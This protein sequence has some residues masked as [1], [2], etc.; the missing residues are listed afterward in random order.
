[1]TV[2]QK[3]LFELSLELATKEIAVL[4]QSD[5]ED[6]VNNL[7]DD[8]KK[9]IG[10]SNLYF[11]CKK[12]RLNFV[13]GTLFFD[14]NTLH[15]EFELF[16]KNKTVKKERVVLNYAES[17]NNPIGFELHKTSKSKIII[18]YPNNSSR[19]VPI[20]YIFYMF[21]NMPYRDFS[22]FA[23]HDITNY[24]ILYIGQSVGNKEKSNSFIRTNRGH[25]KLQK[26]LSYTLEHEP[27]YEIFLV[28]ATIQPPFSIASSLCEFY[29]PKYTKD[30]SLQDLKA[31][32]KSHEVK[33]VVNL[34]E[35]CLIKYFQPKYND[36]LKSDKILGTE[37]FIK[38]Y[39]KDHDINSI[40]TVIDTTNLSIEL[41][42]TT[43][44]ATSIHKIYNP[45]HKETG[46]VT[47]ND[48]LRRSEVIDKNQ[49]L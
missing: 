26:I 4:R 46:R 42:S 48:I 12:P 34:M 30:N 24:E 41:F 29:D 21:R 9:M 37:S 47:I 19:T 1:M 45:I 23:N 15:F 40:L 43:R 16:S 39:T 11:I 5:S 18:Y 10:N 13:P 36:R 38:E 27:H 35:A 44:K 7:E 2:K 14:K 22:Q 32:A 31:L 6:G 8:L 49:E 20:E 28:F 3:F 33:K 25:N 17:P